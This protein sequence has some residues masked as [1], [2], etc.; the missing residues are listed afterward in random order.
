MQRDVDFVGFTQDAIGVTSSLR[1]AD[2]DHTISTQ[3][4]VGCDGAHSLVRKGL[5]I[6][7][8]GDAF[9]EEY[10]LGDVELDWDLPSGY[11]IRSMHRTG[12]A[13]DDL[14]V[15]IPLPGHK[16]YRVSSFVDPELTSA[17]SGDAGDG[18]AHGLQSGRA[19]ELRH[20]QS[21]LDR[22]SPQQPTRVSHLRWSSV[23]RIS[24]RLAGRYSSGRAFLAGDAAHIHPPTGAQGMNTG[25][26][27]AVN[28]AWKL[29]L[30]VSGEA[31]D[32]LLESYHAERHPVGEEVVGRTVRSAG[33]HRRRLP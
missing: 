31:A 15:C 13:V 5:G 24:H 29:A 9:P 18:V 3:Y 19:P 25:I 7:F 21:V 23:F 27:D 8:E 12:D 33:R 2:G 11:A 30:A 20:L 28:L 16:R 10:M 32:G 17:P 6:D 4:L 14:M 26:Q 22:L 1:T